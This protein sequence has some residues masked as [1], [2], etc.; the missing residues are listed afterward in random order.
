MR[1]VK[2]VTVPL[3]RVSSVLAQLSKLIL[4]CPETDEERSAVSTRAKE[5]RLMIAM[6][7][8]ICCY[9]VISSV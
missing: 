8:C 5:E 1:S 6:L 3:A 7:N 2:S 4:D 9:M